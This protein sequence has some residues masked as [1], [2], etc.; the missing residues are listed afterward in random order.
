MSVIKV[1][2]ITSVNGTDSVEVDTHLKIKEQSGTT[3]STSH[4]ALYVDT[5]GALKYQNGAINSGSPVTISTTGVSLSSA[6][7]SDSLQPSGNLLSP[8]SKIEVGTTSLT[9]SS[10]VVRPKS[11]NI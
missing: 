8:R 5:A 1:N 9:N 2:K 6:N 7:A 11:S 10:I 3:T 4:G